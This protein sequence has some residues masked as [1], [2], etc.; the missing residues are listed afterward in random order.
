MRFLFATARKDWRRNRRNLPELALWIG[1]PLII[2]GVIVLAFGGS[3][4]GPAPQAHLLVVDQDGSFLSGVLLGALTQEE[5]GGLIRAEKVDLAE[6]RDRI[7]AGKASALLVIPDGFGAA[8]LDET[9]STLRL[10]VNPAQQ[11]LPGIVEET[12]SMALEAAFYL[13]RL[14]GDEIRTIAAGPPPGRNTL[15]DLLVSGLAIDINQRVERLIEY[16]DPPAI[17]LEIV[18]D[19]PEAGEEVAPD[20]IGVLFLPGILLLSLL[21]MAQGLGNDIWQE[22]EQLTLRRVVVAPRPLVAFLAGKGLAAAGLIVL[23]CLCGLGIGYLYLKLPARTLPLAVVWSLG[24]GVMLLG[25]MSAIQVSAPSQRAG[26]IFGMVLVFPLM[27]LGGSFFP[28]E[29][30]PRWMAAAGALTPNGWA[31]QVLK[32][33]IRGERS[34]LELLPAAAILTALILLFFVYGAIRAPGFARR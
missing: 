10:W 5:A 20:G 15:D 23:V 3:G 34:G 12:L 24:T 13:Q 7:D 33:I 26:Q 19:P 17:E 14:F 11:I 28:F 8:V 31:L 6:G 2:G 22:R 18:E 25:L 16:L 1:I 4:G 21:F 30:M 27:M 32:G 29:A 9:P